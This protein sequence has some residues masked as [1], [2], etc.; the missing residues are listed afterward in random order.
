M[1]CAE[2]NATGLRILVVEDE[3]DVAT[4][5]ASLLRGDGHQVRVAGDGA[6][7]LEAVEEGDPDVVLLDLGL[8]GMDGYEVARRVKGRIALKTPLLIALT[9]L[10]M[11]ADVEHSAEVGIDLH[12]AKPADPALLRTLLQRFQRVVG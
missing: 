7:A 12:L 6:A 4:V 2:T 3:P 1:D 5:T 8:P 11:Q 10:S 9:S